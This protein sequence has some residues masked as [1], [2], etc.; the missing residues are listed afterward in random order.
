MSSV[1]KWRKMFSSCHEHGTEKKFWVPMRNR[2]S[3]LWIPLSDALPLSHRDSM[4]N[5]DIMNVILCLYSESF[6]CPMFMTRWKHLFLDS[7]LPCVCSAIGCTWLQNMARTFSDTQGVG[8]KKLWNYNIWF[9]LFF[10]FSLSFFSLSLSQCCPLIMLG[11]DIF[12]LGKQSF[13]PFFF[14]NFKQFY[15]VIRGFTGGKFH[16]LLPEKESS[17][18]FQDCVSLGKAV[19]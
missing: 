3:D 15:T 13:H 1:K 8:N 16:H 7:I 10:S 4:M 5:K 2:T 12:K 14:K 11:K 19:K 6:L 9:Y 17:V 18:N